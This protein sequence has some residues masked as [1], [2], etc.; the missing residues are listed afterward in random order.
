MYNIAKKTLA[1]AKFHVRSENFDEFLAVS[2]ARMGLA[3]LC[4]NNILSSKRSDIQFYQKLK[5]V[6]NEAQ[7]INII[8]QQSNSYTSTSYKTFL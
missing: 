6:V 2:F 4:T 7:I 8:G 5:V 3:N 1:Q